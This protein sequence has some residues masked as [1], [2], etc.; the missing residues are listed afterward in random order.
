MLGTGSFMIFIHHLR[1]K[2][3][4]IM[5]RECSN[6]R[7]YYHDGGKWTFID[8]EAYVLQDEDIIKFIKYIQYKNPLARG[9]KFLGTNIRF[10]P[11]CRYLVYIDHIFT[12]NKGWGEVKVRNLDRLRHERKHSGPLDWNPFSMLR[13]D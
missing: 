5:I 9:W 6:Y 10:I 11:G 2:G 1:V 4:Y 8:E 3:G 12:L 13:I 7:N